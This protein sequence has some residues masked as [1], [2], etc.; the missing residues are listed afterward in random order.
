[1]DVRFFIVIVAGELAVWTFRLVV[2]MSISKTDQ[3][4][5]KPTRPICAF[6]PTGLFLAY[7][8]ILVVRELEGKRVYLELT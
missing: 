4:R 7:R 2:R 3:N 1:M 5:S 6:S 8:S